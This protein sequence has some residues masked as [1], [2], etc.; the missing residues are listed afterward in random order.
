[1]TQAKHSGD[2]GDSKPGAELGSVWRLLARREADNLKVENAGI[3]D[4][5][6]L[7]DWFHLEKMSERM[8]WMRVG[9]AR[10]LVEVDEEGQ[11]KLTVERGFYAQ[12]P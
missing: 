5:F 8:W 12:Q 11:A 2:S 3:L 1:M 9:D 7:D 4:E 6:V 10:L